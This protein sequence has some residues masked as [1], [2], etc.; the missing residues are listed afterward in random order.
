MTKLI[1]KSVFETN[2]SSCHSIS[3]SSDDVVY[4]GITPA[5]DNKIYLKPMEFGWDI[6]E[7]RD[8]MSK[9]TYCWIYVEDWTD[10]EQQEF[11]QI[12]SNVVCQHTGADE[13]VMEI[14]MNRRWW[15]G[16]HGYIDHQ[17]VECND[18]HYMFYQPE[19][20][21]NFIF[22]PNSVLRTDNDNH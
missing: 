12:L 15:H 22:N 20:L 6:A 17:S 10:R 7:Y 16:K 19:Y 13:I 8:P 5:S 14:D 18:L 3:I 11:R 2:S 4:D 1:R 21:K 9:L